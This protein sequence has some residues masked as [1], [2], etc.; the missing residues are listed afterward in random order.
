MFK[1]L[2]DPGHSVEKPGA[3]GKN[4]EIKEEN[5]NLFQ[6]EVLRGYL[7]SLGITVHI[8]DDPKDDL[9]SI[10]AKAKGYDMFISLH[11][12][13]AN[14]KEHYTCAIVHDSVKPSDLSAS[15]ACNWASV[16]AKAIGNKLYSGD[17]GYP[18]GVMAKKLK[19]LKAAMDAGC[20][21]V[22]TSEIEFIDDET[23][24]EALKA[25]LTKALRACGQMVHKYFRRQEP[26]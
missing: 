3:K 12:N 2:L 5:L 7:T 11:L 18:Q 25:R 15:F 19:V 24:I 26:L 21:V 22:F 16:A 10:G 14:G 13:A 1:V 23:D 6:A 8:V 9:A 17:K 4:P 20:P